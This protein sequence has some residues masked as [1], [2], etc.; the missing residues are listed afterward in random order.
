MTKFCRACQQDKPDEAF[1]KSSPTRCRECFK[2]K[3]KDYQRRNAEMVKA[4]DRARSN[5]PHRVAARHAYAETEEGRARLA[6]GKK[7]WQARN[8]VARAA[9]VILGNAVGHGKIAKPAICSRCGAGGRIHAYHA[10]YSKPLEVEWLCS[11]CHREE[12]REE[13]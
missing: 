5:L 8:P 9:H 6:A 1:Y 3:V 11:P 13:S 10:D 4:K 2:A 7:A 12:H